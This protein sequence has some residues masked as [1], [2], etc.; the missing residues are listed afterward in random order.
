MNGLFYTSVLSLENEC[1]VS[2]SIVRRFESGCLPWVHAI[3]LRCSTE[4]TWVAGWFHVLLGSFLVSPPC[5]C[6][7][8]YD[9]PHVPVTQ[10]KVFILTETPLMVCKV[11]GKSCLVWV[12]LLRVL[13]GF[14]LCCSCFLFVFWSRGILLSIST[15]SSCWP[16]MSRTSPA[17]QEKEKKRTRWCFLGV[18]NFLFALFF[19]VP[20]LSFWSCGLTMT[21]LAQ[22][23]DCHSCNDACSI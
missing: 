1:G 21:I 18:W 19:L 4:R 10:T 14:V 7:C 2:K 5:F 17:M 22:P 15:Y 3:P 8:R 20:D 6:L 23:N 12:W 16:T 9:C 13:F 11:A